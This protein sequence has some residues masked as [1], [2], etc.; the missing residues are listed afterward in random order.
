MYCALADRTRGRLVVYDRG[1]DGGPSSLFVQDAV[2]LDLERIRAEILRRRD[3]LTGALERADPSGLP[4]CPW[5]GR[6]CEYEAVCGCGDVDEAFRPTLADEAP[7]FAANPDVARELLDL[8]PRPA[9]RSHVRLGD[10]IFP[11][12]AHFDAVHPVQET[13]EDRLGDLERRGWYKA[14]RD[15]LDF[16]RGGESAK[17]PVR[18]GE[19]ADLVLYHRGMPTILRTAKLHSL[20][21]RDAVVRLFPNH[22]ARL[23]FECALAGA[24][25]G[26][27]VIYYERLRDEDSRLMVY[28]LTFRDLEGVRREAEGRLAD[29]AQAREGD[30]DPRRLPACPT[31]MAKRCPHQPDCGC[32]AA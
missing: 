20:A 12:R 18:I 17:R 23:A 16:S 15:A 13:D 3:L 8:L 7:A 32:P 5:S 6:G 26:R 19:L 28:D 11:R 22:V 4:R 27:L 25:R 21:S 10:L 1:R 2:F 29:L 24:D 14:L 30:L 31:W 9:P